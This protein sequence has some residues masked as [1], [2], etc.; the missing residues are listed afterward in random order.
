[1]KETEGSIGDW[2]WSG[3]IMMMRIR[4]TTVKEKDNTEKTKIQVLIMRV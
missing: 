2:G 1:M 3:V 4:M